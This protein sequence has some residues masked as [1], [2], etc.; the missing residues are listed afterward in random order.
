MLETSF[1]IKQIETFHYAAKYLNISKA[2]RALNM[3]T[4][5]AW[6]HIQNLEGICNERLFQRDGKYIKLTYTGQMLCNEAAIFLT[7]RQNLA[8]ALLEASST[9]QQPIK[10]SITNTFQRVG[11]KIIQ[12]FIEAF[13]NIK[14]EFTIDRWIEQA[15]LVQESSHDF[16]FISDPFEIDLN[17]VQNRLFTFDHVLVASSENPITHYKKITPENISHFNYLSTR[18]KSI[19]QS[20]QDKLFKQWAMK[21]SPIYV[22]SFMAKKEAVLANLGIAILPKCIIED[23]IK[24]KRLVI[25]PIETN[26]ISSEFI[27]LYNATQ[28]KKGSHEAFF[29]FCTSKRN[30]S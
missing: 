4:P 1:T 29:N 19:T 21:K 24:D 6:K 16:F 25:L 17:L 30:L 2:A 27:I 20:N 3:S 12:P 14:I 15:K 8:N 18:A 13:P 26:L 10:L 28:L 11:F 22:D 23:E 9:E 5:A 7:A